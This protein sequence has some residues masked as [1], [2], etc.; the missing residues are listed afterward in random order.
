MPPISVVIITYNEERNLPRCLDSVKGI[1][2]EIVVV[3]SFSTDKT[4]DIAREYGGKFIR[5][6]FQGHI[7]QK[8][9][10][11]T[12]AKYPH[13]L[14]LDADEALT[15]G[16]QRSILQVKDQW[17]HDGYYFNRLTNYCGQWIKHGG[18]YPDRK[19][20]LFDSRKG[21]WGGVNPHDRYELEE[22]ASREYLTGDL[23]HYCF[24]TIQEHIDQ[25]NKFSEEA[26]IA[27]FEK[28]RRSNTLK[29]LVK[30]AAK[31]LR[32][33]FFKLGFLDGYYGYVICRIS[34]FA[35][36]LRYA[37]LKAMH[38]GDGG[39]RRGKAREWG[40]YS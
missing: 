1:A 2:D 12:Q 32:N 24:Y 34:A 7:E 26:A 11:I 16:L 30:S 40:N 36:F 14:S 10:A 3:D 4:E 21:R 25:T 22:G 15:A 31:F 23:L 27:L 38:Q 9:F 37:K 39:G 5:H 13:I 29:I 20:R 19:L 28:G 17:Q 18:W 8:N 35:T 6:A 33:Y